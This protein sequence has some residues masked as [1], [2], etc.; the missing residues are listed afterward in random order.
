MKD[1]NLYDILN[2][3]E[4]IILEQKNNINHWL[5]LTK[6]ELNTEKKLSHIS[7]SIEIVNKFHSYFHFEQSFCYTLCAYILHLKNDLPTRDEYFGKALFQDRM[8]N[9]AIDFCKNIDDGGL[10]WVFSY[11]RNYQYESKFLQFAIGNFEKTQEIELLDQLIELALT[12]Q[13]SKAKVL[14]KNVSF[15]SHRLYIAQTIIAIG[16]NDLDLSL[17]K[18]KY[19]ISL[20]E[21][22]HKKYHQYAGELY[23]KRAIIFDELGLS[24][25]SKNDKYKSHD[26]IPV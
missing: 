17:D 25:L 26:L 14:Q 1:D 13:I 6:S 24:D 5:T 11:S 16:F 20:L 2:I 21:S 4:N 22:S 15:N 23:G 10:E 9:I 7:R 12:K 3:P 8:N 18:I 19:A